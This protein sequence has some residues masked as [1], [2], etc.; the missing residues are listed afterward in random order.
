VGK[1]VRI[2]SEK[3]LTYVT[4]TLYASDITPTAKQT[5]TAYAITEE[6]FAII[7]F[8][9]FHSMMGH[10]HNA[11]LQETAQENKIQL[12]GVHYRPC[13]NCTEAKIRMKTIPKE[14]RTIS[15]K[16]GEIILIDLFWIKTAS[17][18]HNRYFILIMDE[19]THF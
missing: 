18:V 11:F 5:E 19:Y 17:L 4:G 13:T 6:T 14:S 3:Q 2:D 12:T 15:T 16:K 9:K 7:N 8:D 10:P 1:G